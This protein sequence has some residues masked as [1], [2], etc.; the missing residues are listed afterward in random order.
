MNLS[1]LPTQI[2]FTTG[3]AALKPTIE[4]Y[5]RTGKRAVRQPSSVLARLF[6]TG[7]ALPTAVHRLLKVGIVLFMYLISHLAEEF[8]TEQTI[9]LIMGRHWLEQRNWLDH[10]SGHNQP[11]KRWQC[12]IHGSQITRTSICI[13]CVP[14]S[15]L[16]LRQDSF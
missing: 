7:R 14:A 9:L 3:P 8:E 11:N 12:W 4:I 1:I 2:E 13:P 6:S 16:Q 15:L 5:S 10:Q